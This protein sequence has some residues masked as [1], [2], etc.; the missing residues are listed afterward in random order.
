MCFLWVDHLSI[1]EYNQVKKKISLDFDNLIDLDDVKTLGSDQQNNFFLTRA[2]AAYS[3]SYLAQIDNETAAYSVVDGARDNGIDAI[4]YD[5]KSRILYIVQ[6]KWSYKEKSEPSNGDIKKF[7]G[8]VRDLFNQS[9]ESFNDKVNSKKSIIEEALNDARTKCNIIIAYTGV[10]FSEENKKDVNDFLNEMNDAS[11]LVSIT[12]FDLGKLHESL[13]SKSYNDKIDLTITLIEWAMKNDSKNAF[14]GQVNGIEIAEWWIN[15]NNRL[16]AKNIRELLGDSSI[17]NEI[18]KTI[19]SEPENFW[20]YN[21]GITI[22]ADSVKKTPAGG[23]G[24]LYGAFECKDISIVNGA[25]TVGTIGK[26]LEKN[27]SREYLENLSVSVRLISLED[28]DLNFGKQITRNNNRQNEIKSRDLVAL[29]PFQ[30]SIKTELA[31]DGISYHIMRSSEEKKDQKSFDVV[32]STIALACSRNDSNFAVLVKRNIGILWEDIEKAP[33]KILFN[34]SIYGNYIWKCVQ[35]Q[36]KI[37]NE[38]E[39]L[40][41]E[42]S[43]RRN[44]IAV[45][46]NRIISHFV[47]NELNLDYIKDENIDFDSFIESIDFNERVSVNYELLVEKTSSIFGNNTVIPILFK[48]SQKCKALV[49]KIIDDKNNNTPSVIKRKDTLDE[50]L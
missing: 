6:S 13:I 25:Q 33:Y 26:Y 37:D 29:D 44:A 39:K 16:F 48:N 23:A 22:I 4:H 19:E 8:G 10:N 38:I 9:Y 47:F 11:D 2:L 24:H 46:G 18:E 17:N 12:V 41:N 15:N 14:Y 30:Q 7:F 27:G 49:E 42:T 1:V 21:N 36:R 31:I 34:K 20:Y 40:K 35:I 28:S 3:I 32:E 43:N 50:W 5:T 45:H